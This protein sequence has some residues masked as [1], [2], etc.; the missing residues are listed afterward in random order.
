MHQ[1]ALDK[2]QRVQ[3]LH[4]AARSHAEAMWEKPWTVSVVVYS[5]VWLYYLRIVDLLSL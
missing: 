5:L 2:A 4:L 1:G 3:M